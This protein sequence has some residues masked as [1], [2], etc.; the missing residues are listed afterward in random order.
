[1]RD[2]GIAFTADFLRADTLGGAV[3]GR[4]LRRCPQIGVEKLPRRLRR[5][6]DNNLPRM[7][8]GVLGPT[9]KQALAEREAERETLLFRLGGAGLHRRAA[10]L[11]EAEAIMQMFEARVAALRASLDAI[12]TRTEAAEILAGLNR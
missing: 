3:A 8:A 10:P 7:L 9:L 2:L 12:E 1:M 11:P 6:D 5:P 4:A